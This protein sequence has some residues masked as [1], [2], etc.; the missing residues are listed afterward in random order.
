MDFLF[1]A[2]I[3]PVRRKEFIAVKTNQIS[4]QP[5]AVSKLRAISVFFSV[6]T[7]RVS[8]EASAAHSIY[9][10]RYTELTLLFYEF[11]V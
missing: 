1:V 11:N 6:Y 8:A 3:R 10:P 2:Y 9:S 4:A 7:I 5:S